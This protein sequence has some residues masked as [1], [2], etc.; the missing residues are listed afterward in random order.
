MNPRSVFGRTLAFSV[1]IGVGV[2]RQAAAFAIND[3]SRLAVTQD[4][5]YYNNRVT[6]GAAQNTYLVPRDHFTE[7]LGAIYNPL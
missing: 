5:L 4:F 7:N 1:F 6:G 3:H 2:P